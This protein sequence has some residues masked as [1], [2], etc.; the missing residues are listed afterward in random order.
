MNDSSTSVLLVGRPGLLRNALRSLVDTLQLG[1]L[2]TA[3]GTRLAFD[4]VRQYHPIVMLVATGL[5]I[6]EVIDL[7][8]DVKKEEPDTRC[9]VLTETEP[10]QR[11]FMA[12]GA[13]EVLL[14]DTMHSQLS[15]A[16]I[17]LLECAPST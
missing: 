16:L 15:S 3:D 5:P 7:I 8:R 2:V 11:L 14:I 12:A 10:A 6:Q 9:M 4:D 1:E 13:D 17:N